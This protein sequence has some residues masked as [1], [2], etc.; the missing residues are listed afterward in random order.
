MSVSSQTA[1]E[2]GRPVTELG[3]ITEL[4][5]V[6]ILGI[7]SITPAR[8]ND[9]LY[10][11]VDL[12][13]PEIKALAESIRQHGV[14]D[15]IVITQDQ[16][17]VSGH[18]RFAASRLAG[19]SAVPCREIGLHSSDPA[20]LQTLREF[21][22]QREKTDAERL[23][24]EIVS[25]DP[26]EGMRVL[27]EHRQKSAQ[28]SADFIQIDGHKVRAVI[29]RAKLPFLDAC[30][31]VINERRDF[32]PLSDRQIHYA[33]LNDPPLTHAS[34]PD[35]GYRNHPNCY[36]Q[37]TDLLTRARLERKIPMSVIAD[38]TRPISLWDVHQTP[39]TFLRGQIDDFLKG[40]YRDLQQSQPNH[41]EIVGEKNTVQGVI[42]PVALEYCLPVTTGRGFCS[43]PPR[44][45]MAQ[46]FLKS[47]KENLILLVLSDLDPDGEEI[48]HSFTRSL[49]DDFG[50]KSV[51]AI[52]VTLTRAQVDHFR[53]P[54]GMEAKTGSATYA[55]FVGK[56][57]K[58]VYELEALPP[59][60][61]QALLR[62]AIESVLDLDAFN[63]Q[64]EAEK[65]DA[66]SLDVYRRRVHRLL[67]NEFEDQPNEE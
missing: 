49:R 8:Q 54:P 59:A 32:W 10:R 21:N 29:S 61:L 39:R 11:P 53:L 22:R 3:P 67:G 52:K 26:E 33:L 44:Y 24:E 14:M 30:I 37:L 35:S 42:K 4:G 19:L 56:Y 51:K 48:C 23:R 18:R 58:A 1:S 34:K 31:R 47:G 9:I 17:I 5:L 55:K 60:T 41:V 46:R 25:A 15:P 57:G 20:F 28:V 13:D 45:E 7:G 66:Q 50:I 38:E 62:Q 43:L 12:A 36:K 27:V 2:L 16:I 65:G 63:A 6:R 64:I 40:Y